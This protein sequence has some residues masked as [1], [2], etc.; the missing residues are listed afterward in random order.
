[1]L[2]VVC[3][4]VDTPA[5]RFPRVCTTILYFVLNRIDVALNFHGIAIR[6]AW[7][8]YRQNGLSLALNVPNNVS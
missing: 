8:V 2:P 7:L 6:Q 5:Q 1:M 3:K 4:H